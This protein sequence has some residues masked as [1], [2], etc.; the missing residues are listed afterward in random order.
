[1]NTLYSEDYTRK[2]KVDWYDNIFNLE[3]EKK[4]YSPFELDI[5][6]KYINQIFSK[7]EKLS[8]AD[9]P[10]GFGRISKYLIKKMPNASFYGYDY[11]NEQLAQVSEKKIELKQQDILDFNYKNKFDLIIS[12]RVLIHFSQDID[13]IFRGFYDSLRDNSYL[14]FNIHH[15]SLSP[16]EVIRK[17]TN[18]KAINSMNPFTVEKILK[19][20]GFKILKKKGIKYIPTRMNRKKIYDLELKCEQIL[21]N[22]ISNFT[23]LADN[24]VYLVQKKKGYNKI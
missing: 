23:F 11:S 19:N 16:F 21:T 18:N 5:I 7:D 1:M 20:I 17:M 4:I 10:I 15:S 24:S 6:Q 14:I 22:N 8:I 12:M 3:I 2:E 9:I 13:K